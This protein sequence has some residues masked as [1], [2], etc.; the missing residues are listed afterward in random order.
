M[1]STSLSENSTTRSNFVPI[2]VENSVGLGDARRRG[3]QTWLNMTLG[4]SCSV[5]QPPPPPIDFTRSLVAPASIQQSATPSIISSAPGTP[6][7][8][9]PP[10]QSQT[11]SVPGIQPNLFNP[12]L[13]AAQLNVFNNPQIMAMMQRPLFRENMPPGGGPREGVVM[14]S[15]GGE[16]N[17]H[18][19]IHTTADQGNA[20]S[21]WIRSV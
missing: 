14:R 18:M 8:F 1:A 17:R 13:M 12:A 4:D 19:Y 9:Q 7:A 21:S 6:T 3:P 10:Q 2:I 20:P 16:G 15:T 5:E 11:A